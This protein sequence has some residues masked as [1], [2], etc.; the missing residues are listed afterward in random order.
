MKAVTGFILEKLNARLAVNALRS[1]K[2]ETSL[3]DF[4]SNDYLGFSR[5]PELKSLFELQLEKYP[6]YK[7]GS[8][9]SR[10]LSGND[11]FTEDLE[12]DIAKFH[13]CE[14]SL[15]FNSGYDANMGIFS[16]LPQ[17]DDTIICDE[18]IHASI[19]DGARLS[20]AARFVFKHNDMDSLE[21]K[22]KAAKGRIFIGIE[23]VYSMDGGE[24]P[25]EEICT[26]AEKYNG[27]VIV[28]EAHAIG[29]FGDHGRG[30]VDEL[31]LSSRVFARIVTF[32][33]ALGVH[34]AAILGSEDLRS[35]LI[36]YARSF[37]YT[38]APSFLSH[39]AIKTSYDYLKSKNHQQDLHQIIQNFRSKLH[40]VSSLTASRSGIQILLIPGNTQA[41]EIASELQQTGFDVRAILSPTVSTGSERLRICLHNHNSF[42]EVEALCNSLKFH[43]EA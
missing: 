37:I 39:L 17:R 35:Y 19:I 11:K 40:T 28:D 31:N 43:C 32:G 16:S 12:A 6:E 25:L 26:L 42:E 2:T 33:K 34:G 15:L 10:L 9:G 18:Y 21:Q 5:S 38:T 23:S 27:A 7:L 22:L 29:I 3:I 20:H 8:T 13:N 30:I 4:C 41:R 36:N 14:A 1:L 24:A